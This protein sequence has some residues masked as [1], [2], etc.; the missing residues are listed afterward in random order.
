[1]SEGAYLRDRILPQ[2]IEDG[3][4]LLWT[5]R[6]NKV[7]APIARGN[8]RRAMWEATKGS[9]PKGKTPHPVCGRKTCLEHLELKTISQIAILAT[10]R[11]DVR[12][13]RSLAAKEQARRRPQ[14]LTAVSVQ[15]L[16]MAPGTQRE[17]AAAF[18]VAQSLVSRIDNGLVWRDTSFNPFAGIGARA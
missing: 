17:R 1:M 4:C 8:V 9:I 14:K 13:R 11:P 5:G 2:C 18:G 6:V 16:R 10:N 3:D 15:E 12:A 7:G